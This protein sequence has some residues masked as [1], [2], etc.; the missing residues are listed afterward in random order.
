MVRMGEKEMG[1]GPPSRLLPLLPPPPAPAWAWAWAVCWVLPLLWVPGRVGPGWAMGFETTPRPRAPHRDGTR[2]RSLRMTSSGSRGGRQI[3]GGAI[4][5]VNEGTRASAR[6]RARAWVWRKKSRAA[7]ARIRTSLRR[8]R[9]EPS[10]A[11]LAKAS[12]R[13]R[14]QIPNLI[15]L[16]M[17]SFCKMPGVVQ[18][19]VFWRGCG[20]VCPSYGAR[21]VVH[22]PSGEVLVRYL[23]RKQRQQQP[24]MLRGRRVAASL[25]PVLRVLGHSGCSRAGGRQWR[26]ITR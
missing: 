3:G 23:V 25:G 14:N 22:V 16:M 15:V 13:I 12:G 8:G 4:A 20:G 6:A 5:A 18:L 17:K 24:R 26:R 1:S 21:W 11:G 9:R 7:R 2:E 19:C 10:D